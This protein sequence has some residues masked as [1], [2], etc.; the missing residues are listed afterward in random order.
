MGSTIIRRGHAVQTVSGNSSIRR[1]F[2]IV[3]TNNSNLKATLRFYYFDA[4]LRGSPEA[5]LQQW[6][7]QNNTN[8][9]FVGAD[10]RDISA[11]YVE[12]KTIASFSRWTL[13][14]A[15]APAINCPA[16]KAVTATM[17][18]CKAT[19]SFSAT[20]TGTPT[21]TITYSIGNKTITSP[22][23]FPK[24]TTTVTVT[25]SNGVA[26]NATCTFTV[27]VVCGGSATVTATTDARAKEAT[28][29]K[30]SLSA[31]PNPANQYFTL[32]IKSSDPRPVTIRVLDAVGRVLTTRSNLAPNTSLYIGHAYRP[33]TY[34]A[35]AIQGKEKV[36]LK[37]VKQVY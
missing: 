14:T 28:I 3:P 33:G 10:S 24:G 23:V 30:L 19:V 17:G 20:A 16:N 35:Q 25:A 2:D 21:P 6:K 27:T 32:D 37:L 34:Y 1:Y 18:G 31:R 8:W 5:T 4:E 26:P 12:K 9:D 13:A 36:T 22:Y 11:N 29:E 15:T 7:T